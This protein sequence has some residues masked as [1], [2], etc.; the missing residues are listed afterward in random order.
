MVAV[1]GDA[2]DPGKV[3]LGIDNGGLHARER[4]DDAVRCG[5]RGLGALLEGLGSLDRLGIDLALASGHGACALAERGGVT[6]SAPKGLELIVQKLDGKGDTFHVEGRHVLAHQR[7]DQR[8]APVLEEPAHGTPDHE[9]LLVLGGAQAIQDD[10]DALRVVGRRLGQDAVDQDP[11]NLGGRPQVILAYAGLPV[12]ALADLHLALGNVEQRC[13][14][15][16]QRAATEAHGHGARALVG[17]LGDADEVVE[18]DAGC[19]SGTGGL[20]DHEGA[21][22][23]A[24]LLLLFGLGGR[25][26]IGDVEGAAI[27]ALPN[28]A[29]AGHVEVHLVARIVTAD[30]EDAPTVVDGASDPQDVLG[31]RRGEHVAHHGPVHEAIAHDAAERG[32][33][34]GTTTVDDGDLAFGHLGR[35]GDT[36]G[37]LDD[38]VRIRSDITPEHVL[39]E[40]LGIVVEHASLLSTG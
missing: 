5:V 40:S 16:R 24:T 6:G 7:L 17:L 20:E 21:H 26:V 2:I 12:D 33:V 39:A 35:T 36:T 4:V 32:I 11:G 14:L 3:V 13:R 9:E 18:R 31:G 29:V 8:V 25:D 38:I 1:T 19:R 23:A 37:D 15:A 10:G 27:D 22:V 34:A 30:D 28:K